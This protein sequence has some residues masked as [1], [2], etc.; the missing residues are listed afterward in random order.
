[1]RPARA[2]SATSAAVVR[3]Q[4]FVQAERGFGADGRDVHQDLDLVR[5]HRAQFDVEAHVPGG[6]QFAE[7]AAQA[8]AEPWQVQ[9]LARGEP[10]A[11]ILLA[12]EEQSGGAAVGTNPVGIVLRKFEDRGRR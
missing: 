2:A 10:D 11:G 7:F 12:A 5:H 4:L 9:F 3:P 8:D 6:Q 1:M